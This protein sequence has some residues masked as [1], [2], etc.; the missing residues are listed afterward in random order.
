M[1]ATPAYASTINV[2][3][4]ITNTTQD[5]STTAP[6][7]IAT[8]LTAG[9]SGSRIESVRISQL[10]TTSAAGIINIFRYDGATY[11]LLD[12]FAYGI[13]TVSA[14]ASPNPV[15]M[16]IPNLVLKSG[17]TLRVTN[18]VLSNTGATSASTHKV[19]AF[20]ADF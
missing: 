4:V 7:A 19:T 10:I 8:V 1:S 14:T 15:D 18:T 6:S 11:H 3:S 12:F 9:A 13:G 2:G 5:T 17:D 16:Y 20:G